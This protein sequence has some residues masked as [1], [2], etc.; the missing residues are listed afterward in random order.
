MRILLVH[1][2]YGS[3]APSGENQVFEAEKSLLNKNGDEVFSF[4]RKSDEIIGQRIL[5]KIRGAVATPWNPW[6]AHQ[7]KAAVK[8][9]RPDVVHVHN[10][11]PMISPAIFSAIGS[12]A[13]RVLTLHN[14]RLFCAAA[15]PLREGKVCIDCLDRKSSLPAIAHGCYRGSRFATIPLALN[16]SLHRFLGTWTR[17]VDSFIALSEFQRD[18]MS[19]SGLI[20]KKVFVKPNFYPGNPRVISWSKR[21]RY[22]VF[23]GRLTRE[24]GVESLLKAWKAW[25][26]GA[27]RLRIV[28]DG[29][30]R[31]KLETM[32][33][34][35]PVEFLGQLPP[36]EAQKQIS[37]SRLLVLPSE[38]FEG[39]PMVIREAFAFGT[40]I[41]VSDI[42]PLPSLIRFGECGV[43][44]QP[45]APNSLLAEVK[46]LWG[47]EKRL[48]Q[49]A[50]SSRAEFETK[51]TEE[52]NYKTL[53]NIYEKAQWFSK[54]FSR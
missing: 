23:V 41:A 36:E 34:G 54:N 14:Y 32:S 37:G 30:L 21:E 24:K 16:V 28:G 10:T 22:V 53:M 2:F 7:I 48:K 51:Y 27:P 1:N 50:E 49:C 5:G 19:R 17:D 45:G 3:S 18:L 4:V 39:F 9:C 52:A 12:R 29:E 47:D 33:E 6:S 15:I 40:P 13:A 35:L 8:R 44:F 46:A 20:D 43:V 25:G 42:G 11:F 26:E 31:P 38:W